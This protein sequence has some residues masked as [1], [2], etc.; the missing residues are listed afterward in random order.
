VEELEGQA[1]RIRNELTDLYMM[2]ETG[3]I[4]EDEFD[5]RE[6]ALLDRLDQ[7]EAEGLADDE[8]EEQDEDED[9]DDEIDVDAVTMRVFADDAETR[10]GAGRGRVLETED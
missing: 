2:L 3:Q 10:T 4:E 7:L 5:Q 9:E 8:D 6:S 1:E